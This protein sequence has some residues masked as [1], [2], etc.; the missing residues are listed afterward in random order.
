MTDRIEVRSDVVDVQLL[1]LG[2]RR[3]PPV[4]LSPGLGA[5]HRYYELR[6]GLSFASFLSS[7]DRT[8]WAIDFDV[9][10]RR[11]TEDASGLLRALEMALAELQREEGVA[12]DEVD[13]VGHSLGGLLLLA[14]AVD[15][16]PLRRIVALATGLDYRLGSPWFKKLL[17]LT[18]RL[19]GLATT[20]RLPG[21][22]LKGIAR[23]GSRLTG[24]KTLGVA[25]DQ[26]HPGATDMPTVRR[27]LREGVR[28]LSLPLLL[29][30]ASLYSDD[31]LRLG[32]S[33]RPL[34]EAVGELRCPALFVAG[35][36]DKVC[37]V[38][39]VRDAAGRVPGAELLEVGDGTRPGEG[40]G[41]VDLLTG[42]GALTEVF[43]PVATFLEA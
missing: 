43:H 1:R 11:D 37:T 27:F 34:K 41:H 2:P 36:Q 15:G 23:I 8:P 18:P 5:N 31:G 6:A 24:W 40:Y 33:G 9:S 21:L 13:A 25:S 29:D 32:A 28:D 35:R 39:S 20:A 17:G 16:L 19:K 26:F 22:P 30:L 7:R 10:W 38:E 14:L 4:L 3:G 42:R 12:L